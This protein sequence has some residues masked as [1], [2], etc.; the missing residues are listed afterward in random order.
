MPKTAKDVLDLAKA[1]GVNTVDFR[2]MDF[3]GTWQHFST[4]LKEL[5]DD[6]FKDGLGFDG[7]TIRGWSHIHE[8]DML[9]IPDPVTAFIDP[10]FKDPTLV[11]MCTIQDPTTRKDYSRDPRNVALKAEKYLKF[12]GIGD[13]FPIRVLHFIA[14]VEA[15]KQTM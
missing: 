9:V 3:I 5:T 1:K 11:L 15:L 6:V 10:F 2:F 8:S 14:P 4:P 13:T 12:T 7:S